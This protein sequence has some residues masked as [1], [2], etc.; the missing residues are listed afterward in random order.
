MPHSPA[1]SAADGDLTPFPKLLPRL[2]TAGG[3]LGLVAAFVL[4]VEKIALLKNPAYVPSCSINPVLSCGSV[5]STPQAEVFGFPN[6][7][8]GVVAFAVV[9][10]VGVTLLAGAR[11]PRW[12]WLGLQAGVT[13]G[14]VFVHWLIYQSLYVI[15]ALCPYCML[16]WAVTVPLFWYVTLRNLARLPA[17]RRAAAYHGVVVTVWFLAVITAIG[18]RFW[19]YWS[20]LL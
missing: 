5:M 2:L 6:P 18:V 9:T 17:A 7:L 12:F 15:G 20:T 10:T 16:V 11:L 1:E 4:A 8:L 13:F 19:S 14:V 3:A